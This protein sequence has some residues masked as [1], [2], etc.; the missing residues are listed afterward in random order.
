M[1]NFFINQEIKTIKDFDTFD[2]WLIEMV[3]IHPTSTKVSVQLTKICG[4]E[5]LCTQMVIILFP[6][7]A[8]LEFQNKKK[9]QRKLKFDYFDSLI[10]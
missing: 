10:I 9:N 8:G 6:V 7:M 3:N 4:S 2:F 1:V 5:S